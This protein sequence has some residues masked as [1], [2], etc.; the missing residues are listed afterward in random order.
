MRFTRRLLPRLLNYSTFGRCYPRAVRPRKP[1]EK[2]APRKKTPL[3][4]LW[5]PCTSPQRGE[6]Y[7]STAS[8]SANSSHGI[9][10]GAWSQ[11]Q[12]ASQPLGLYAPETELLNL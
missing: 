5:S 7:S 4:P 3:S 2:G 1:H 6:R 10:P 11:D 8:Y 9:M 12:F